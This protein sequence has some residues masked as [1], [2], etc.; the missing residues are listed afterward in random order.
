MFY[1]VW[2]RNWAI[3]RFVGSIVC[4]ATVFIAGSIL[5]GIFLPAYSIVACVIFGF[6]TGFIAQSVCARHYRQLKKALSIER[7]VS[8]LYSLVITVMAHSAKEVLTLG[9]DCDITIMR[10]GSSAFELV[11]RFRRDH[12][13]VYRLIPQGIYAMDEKPVSDFLVESLIMEIELSTR[14]GTSVSVI[15]I[16]ELEETNNIS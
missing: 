3:A 15:V 2:N 16:Q 9:E 11:V 10:S 5:I 12:E 8:R 4:F 13:D 7:R 1:S 6:L 14:E